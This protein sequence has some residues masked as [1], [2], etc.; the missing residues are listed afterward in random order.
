MPGGARTRTIVKHYLREDGSTKYVRHLAFERRFRRFGDAWY[1]EIT[2]TYYFTRD[3]RT[4]DRFSAS[5]LAGIKRLERHPDFRRNVESLSWLLSGS[6]DLGGFAPDH[7][8]QLLGFGDLV[9]VNLDTGN[10]D[11]DDEPEEEHAVD[12]DDEENAA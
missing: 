3:G 9:T 12:A 8:S 10:V 4:E 2:P 6:V 5:H 1:L 7:D 11:I